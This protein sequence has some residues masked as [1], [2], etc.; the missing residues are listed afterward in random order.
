MSSTTITVILAVITALFA[1]YYND[2]K[3]Y[4]ELIGYFR[5]DAAPYDGSG[6][7]RI[8]LGPE[9]CEDIVIHHPSGYAFMACGFATARSTQYWP[10]LA[11]YTNMSFEPRDVAWAYNINTN[12]ASVLKIKN[13]PENTDLSFHGLGIYGDSTNHTKVSLFFVNHRR[14][15]SVIEIFEHTIGTEELLHLETVKHELIHTPND[16]VPVSAN[17]FFVTNDHRHKQKGISRHFEAFAQRP[18][19]NV[20]F[21]SSASNITRI[22]ADGIATANGISASWDKSLIY[23]SS[24]ARGEV[25]VYERR[26]DNR[27]IESERIRL[28]YPLD[29]ISID[30]LTG[31]IYIAGFPKVLRNFVYFE[32]PSGKSPKPPSIVLKISNNTDPDQY[33]GKKYKV[34]NVLEADG[35]LF[36]SITIPAVDHER[37]TLLLGSIFIETLRC[38]LK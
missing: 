15:G 12:K 19:S 35:E 8:I 18:W 2:I 36:H 3:Y 6:N 22:A 37:N 17:E 34:T 7:C 25:I 33:F 10:P 9:A 1:Y 23:V 27:L 16:V 21:H 13:L 29:N 11:V 28:G 38:D 5:D 4:L 31:E 30:E 24:A 32:D 14:T 20:V 26:Q